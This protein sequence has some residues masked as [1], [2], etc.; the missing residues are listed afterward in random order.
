MCAAYRGVVIEQSLSDPG[1]PDLVSVLGS[2]TSVPGNVVAGQP[3]R[4]TL[5]TF[6]LAH[7]RAAA[8]AKVFS[9]SLRNG[10]W[11]ID[12][13]NGEHVFVVFA[14]HCFSYRCG[15]AEEQSRARV[16]AR[17]CGVPESQIDW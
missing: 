2:E 12:M 10:P 7:A 13:N 17:A 9:E 1:C 3:E 15:D 14:D 5:T 11:Y 6:E 8:V 4:W 16:H